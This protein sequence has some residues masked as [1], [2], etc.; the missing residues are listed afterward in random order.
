MGYVATDHAAVG[1]E[2]TL[3]IRG[4][5]NPATVASL[6]FVTQSYKR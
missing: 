2:V 6:P 4:K 5:P 1:T 3:M